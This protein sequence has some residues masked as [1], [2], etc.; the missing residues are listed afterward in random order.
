MRIV[1]AAAM[2]AFQLGGGT[3]VEAPT[4]DQVKTWFEAGQYQQ[5]VDAA[6]TLTDPQVQYLAAMSYE[7]LGQSEEARVAYQQLVDRGDEDL[8]ALIGRSASALLTEEGSPLPEAVEEAFATAQRAVGALTPE[9]LTES[10]PPTGAVAAMVY[11]QMGIVQARRLDYEGAAAAFEHVTTFDPAFA[12]AYYY[13]GMANSRI[14][15]PD[16]M[17]INFERFL[18]LAPEAPE[19]PR[20]QSLMR[21]VRG[22]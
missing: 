8:W 10:E 19:A 22:R 5:V 3:P 21:S 9:P 1:A 17:A 7:K 14:D 15:R 2:F 20:V 12:Y 4:A 13:G 16:Q 6:P 18:Q 11:Y